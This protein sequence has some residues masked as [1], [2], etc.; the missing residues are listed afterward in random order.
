AAGFL[1]IFLL[2]ELQER[3]HR[4]VALIRAADPDAGAALLERKAR[5]AGV[6][7][8]LEAIEVV[9]GDLASPHLGLAPG[10]RACLAATVGTIVHNGAF[11]HH[12]H[13]YQTIRAANVL[14]TR[15]LLRLALEERPKRFCLVSTKPACP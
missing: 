11:V 7:I 12:L 5:A 13:G 2:A 3:G 15:E 6:A 9:P 8:D 10:Q 4:V 1:G 14:G